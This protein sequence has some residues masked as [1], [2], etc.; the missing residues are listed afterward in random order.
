MRIAS[1]KHLYIDQYAACELEEPSAT[2]KLEKTALRMILMA[3]A[4]LRNFN[5]SMHQAKRSATT[6]FVAAR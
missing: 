5:L 6:Q 4:A 3:D 1:R 2:N